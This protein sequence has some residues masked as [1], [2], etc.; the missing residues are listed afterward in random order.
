[1]Y[2]VTA[3]GFGSDINVGFRKLCCI[4]FCGGNLHDFQF[5][6]QNDQM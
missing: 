1:M 5:I 4:H 2:V 6:G 3:S